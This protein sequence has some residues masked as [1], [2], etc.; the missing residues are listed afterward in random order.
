MINFKVSPLL[1]LGVLIGALGAAVSPA[2]AQT[3]PADNPLYQQYTDKV[4]AYV[5]TGSQLQAA[6]T[7][8]ANGSKVQVIRFTKSGVYNVEGMTLIHGVTTLS[9]E[10][11][12]SF[13]M[14]PSGNTIPPNGPEGTRAENYGVTLVG[15]GFDRF[16]TIYS[17]TVTI[18]GLTLMNYSMPFGNY[19]TGGSF[20]ISTK[21]KS[22]RYPDAYGGT[23]YNAG[24]LTLENV[25]IVNSSAV[26]LSS[27]PKADGTANADDPGGS[28][29]GG[30]VYSDGTLTMQ[31]CLILNSFVQ[32]DAFDGS[33]KA[34]GGGVYTKGTAT[35][36]NC[37]FENTHA[38]G[39]L[40]DYGATSNGNLTAGGK[41]A[42][43]GAIANDGT[44]TVRNITLTTSSAEAQGTEVEADGAYGGGLYGTSSF[45]LTNSF[46]Q[47][48]SLD[49]GIRPPF[50]T[51]VYK[52][53]Q[54]IGIYGATGTGTSASSLEFT[55]GSGGNHN[56]AEF[57]ISSAVTDL[58]DNGG[59][60]LT[61]APA[62][63]SS[64]LVDGGIGEYA[65]VGTVDQRGANRILLGASP[66]NP[67]TAGG[68]PVVDIGAVEYD[69]NN[70][71][72]GGNTAPL[73][74]R[75]TTVP[76]VAEGENG[77]GTI[78][79]SDDNGNA[80]TVKDANDAD[81]SGNASGSTIVECV[82][83]SPDAI[84]KLG[85]D[86][87]G[88]T[89]ISQ[90]DHHIVMRGTIDNINNALNGLTLW[91]TDQDQDYPPNFSITINDLGNTGYGGALSYDDVSVHSYTNPL[92]NPLSYITP[93][94]DPP[95]VLAPGTQYVKFNATQSDSNTLSFS[96]EQGNPIVVGDL[97]LNSK[98]DTTLPYNR[99]QLQMKVDLTVS[100]GKLIL[101]DTTG[102]VVQHDNGFKHFTIEGPWELLNSALNTL[103]YRPDTNYAGSDSLVIV[104]DDLGNYGEGGP[105]T[106]TKTVPIVINK[107]GKGSA[108]NSNIGWFIS[109][110]TK[111]GM[112]VNV[113]YVFVNGSNTDITNFV[114]SGAITGGAYF[115][116]DNAVISPSVGT[117]TQEFASPKLQRELD[118]TKN[119]LFI[120]WTTP[121]ND[122]T[123]S[124]VI[125]QGR[126]ISLTVSVPFSMEAIG[127]QVTGPWKVSFDQVKSDGNAIKPSPTPP[128][129]VPVGP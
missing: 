107:D 78:T 29:L 44:I 84:V 117:V 103:T 89:I 70:I 95:F 124:I 28:A 75:D 58:Q 18:K 104:V 120:T 31:G 8:I 11:P 67:N 102:L 85:P 96:K 20:A 68:T 26:A 17:G 55:G 115:D 60:T 126:R 98:D 49:R 83:D 122:P 90:T 123:K 76:N 80:L 14:D 119:G 16:L 24:T 111:T 53:G 69:P 73:L 61:R 118:P 34:M 86:T 125:R 46:L 129:V 15:D 82:I 128:A 32:T 43:G 106:A 47:D 2:R 66:D 93:Q 65:T 63:G 37:T 19:T 10:G 116:T 57:G 5:S 9:I 54:Q 41:F 4:V 108:Q 72:S 51:T 112:K 35:I 64:Y 36:K 94:N 30:A 27:H 91:V 39:L 59:P 71:I 21:A 23:I 101:G 45:P 81:G 99:S 13:Y 105:L 77:T 97:D 12:G 114:A 74:E 92:L 110:I 121:S 52:F 33:T 109:D 25:T 40:K 7:S 1:F 62:N 22:G 87:S 127:K 100:H 6:Y 113:T 79:F 42:A 48:C 56:T 50:G 88:V 38:Y 3:A